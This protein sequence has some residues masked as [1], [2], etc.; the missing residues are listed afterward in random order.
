MYDACQGSVSEVRKLS[1][2]LV[3][4]ANPDGTAAVLSELNTIQDD[5]EDTGG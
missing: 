5:W 3:D 2:K 4:K 1:K